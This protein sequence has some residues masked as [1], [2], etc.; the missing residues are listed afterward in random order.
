MKERMKQVLIQQKKV[1]CD[2]DQISDVVSII[3]S[4]TPFGSSNNQG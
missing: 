2:Y 3:K 4:I 1:N